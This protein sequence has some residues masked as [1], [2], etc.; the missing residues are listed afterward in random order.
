M[1]ALALGFALAATSAHAQDVAR[2]FTDQGKTYLR[3]DSA[4]ALV[5]GAELPAFGDQAG[6][7]PAGK[8]IVMEVLGQLV[9]VTYEDEA[10]KSAAK[11]VRVG[12]GAAA[13]PAAGAAGMPPPPPP[14]PPPSGGPP[15]PP[16]PLQ[17]T[18][19]RGSGLIM[20]RNDSKEEWNGCK[21]DFPDRRWAPIEGSL[22]PG[23]SVNVGYGEIKPAPDLGNDWLL[24]RCAEGE[25]ELYFDQPLKTNSLKGR[26]EGRGGGVLIFNDGPTDWT[27]CDLIKPNGTRF[28]QGTLRAKSSDSVR[29]GL[30]KPP[31]GPEIIR[32]TCNQGTVSRPVP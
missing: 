20:V 29:A 2:L 18:L 19:V 17:A 5:P 7:K 25:A 10:N 1:R 30:F 21:L 22:G 13:A 12:R 24:V 8:V 15:P 6:T 32:L 28:A 26:A 23:R 27:Q 9:R 11:F 16:P 3:T 31:S 14:P 4:G